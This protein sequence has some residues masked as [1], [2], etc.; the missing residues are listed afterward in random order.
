MFAVIALLPSVTLPGVLSKLINV[1]LIVIPLPATV[2]N[3]G[4]TILPTIVAGATTVCCCVVP[5]N[6]SVFPSSVN[7][8]KFLT[9]GFCTV[10]V[11]TISF[12]PIV[13]SWNVIVSPPIFAT[14]PYG[15]VGL[16][17]VPVSLM[18]C[19]VVVSPVVSTI[20]LYS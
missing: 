20:H 10:P 12:N 5:L 7:V 14:V 18:P 9:I 6:T 1:P 3:V 19:D 13:V 16:V 4:F 8:S 2:G 11:A 17:L 15:N